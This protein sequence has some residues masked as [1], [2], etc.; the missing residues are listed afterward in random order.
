MSYKHLTKKNRY[1]I[2]KLYN[3]KWSIR[4]IATVIGVHYSTISRE[5][6]RGKDSTGEYVG[7]KAHQRYVARQHAKGR[8][9]KATWSPEQIANYE[10]EINI[11]HKTIYNWIYSGILQVSFQ[12]LRRKGAS[13]KIK[14]SRGKFSVG[15]SIAERPLAV[16]AREEFGH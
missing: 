8:H 13:R 10:A 15:T 16:E 14:D 4:K 11:S 3:L 9:T 5:I 12:V 7:Y 1:L 2:E 6:K